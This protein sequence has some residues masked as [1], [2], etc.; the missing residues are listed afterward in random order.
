MVQ[1]PKGR[2]VSGDGCCAG[3]SWGRSL[4][5][6]S[7]PLLLR[8]RPGGDLFFQI[9]VCVLSGLYFRSHIPTENILV[10]CKAALYTQGGTIERDS[11]MGNTDYYD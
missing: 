1:L 4:S 11:R 7:R 2:W 10:N 9:G 8:W 5:G 6:A 3:S